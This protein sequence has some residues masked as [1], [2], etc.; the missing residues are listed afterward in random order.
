MEPE[1][2]TAGMSLYGD[3]AKLKTFAARFASTDGSEVL[4]FVIRPSNQLKIT[5]LEAKDVADLGSLKDAASIFVPG[6]ATLY[7][8]RTIEIKEDEGSSLPVIPV[9]LASSSPEASPLK[10]FLSGIVNTKPWFQFFGDGFSI[11]VPPQFEDIMEPELRS[12]ECCHSP[13]QS[14]EIT[15]LVIEDVSDLG[16]L[17]DAASI[18]FPGGETLFSARTRKMKEDEGFRTYYFYEFSRDEQHIALVAVVKRGG[19]PFSAVFIVNLGLRFLHTKLRELLPVELHSNLSGMM[20][21]QCFALLQFH[22]RFYRLHLEYFASRFLFES[23]LAYFVFVRDKNSCSDAIFF[24]DYLGNQVLDYLGNQ[25][26][27][28]LFFCQLE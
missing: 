27:L 20:M 13:I 14:T 7:S 5:F 8:A 6:G 1:D 9:V 28:C 21:E 19:V 10:S 11:R 4:S 12:P 26:L 2:Y 25:V 22:W 23:S 18:F 24:L 3:K 16:S 17:K 15:F